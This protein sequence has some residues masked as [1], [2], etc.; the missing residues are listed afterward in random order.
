MRSRTALLTVAALGLSLLT[1]CGGRDSASSNTL[2]IGYIAGSA[3]S[4]P[5]MIAKER[6]IFED[7]GL[8]VQFVNTDSGPGLVNLL[9]SESVDVTWAP[10]SNV[11]AATEK[12]QIV[13]GTVR[14]Y[15]FELVRRKGFADSSTSLSYPDNLQALAEGRVGIS[16]TASYAQVMAEGMF[17]EA[18]VAPGN[19]DFLSVGVGPTSRGALKSGQ[20]DL[21]MANPVTAAELQVAGDGDPVISTRDIPALKNLP[22]AAY[23]T[24]RGISKAQEEKVAK[25]LEAAEEAITWA[26]SESNI[27]DFDAL[28]TQV[29]GLSPDDAEAT[30]ERYNPG[31]GNLI[32]EYGLSFDQGGFDEL[33]AILLKGKLLTEKVSYDEATALIEPR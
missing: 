30:A 14:S 19:L 4:L 10:T 24:K 7:A 29:Y 21:L 23:V 22:E 6:G 2:R 15:G 28:L 25:Y 11:L 27:E 17:N 1:A 12:V 5:D 26:Q 16:A 18:G 33:V 20:V 3:A 9:L 32:G 8:N 13:A 31:E